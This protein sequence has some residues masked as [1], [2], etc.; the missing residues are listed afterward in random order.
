MKKLKDIRES[1]FCESVESGHSAHDKHA[2]IAKD[3][4]I[5]NSPIRMD[6]QC[7]YS[8]ISRG[9]GDIYLRL[10]VSQSYEEKIWVNLI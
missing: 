1:R 4:G 6:S 5:T 8:S 2:F 9:D 10:P 3:L 7:K